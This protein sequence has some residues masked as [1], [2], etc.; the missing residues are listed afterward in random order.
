MTTISKYTDE[1]G[2]NANAIL[3]NGEQQS[4]S[5]TPVVPTYSLLDFIIALC[6]GTWQG[7]YVQGFTK[8]VSADMFTLLTE[9]SEA[10]VFGPNGSESNLSF[11][12]VPDPSIVS[13]S[14]RILLQNFGSEG[15]AVGG[16]VYMNMALLG[17]ISKR[18]IFFNVNEEA[19]RMQIE[20][21]VAIFADVLTLSLK[22]TSISYLPI[23]PNNPIKAYITLYSDSLNPQTFHVGTIPY[24]YD[25]EERPIF[26]NFCHN[27]SFN[28][29]TID[30]IS[31]VHATFELRNSDRVLVGPLAL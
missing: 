18:D 19:I 24:D 21:F 20:G 23:A 28:S 16:D 14:D 25:L 26:F 8:Y 7:G 29:N 4:T 31:L 6:T 12:S 10:F 1:N 17:N 30:A 13:D 2:V 9:T 15:S 5:C 11:L 22:V 27:I 3:S